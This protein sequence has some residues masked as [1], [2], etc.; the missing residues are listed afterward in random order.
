ML[1][2]NTFR[3]KR[4]LRSKFVEGKYLL[5]SEATDLELEILDV[6]RKTVQN[7]LG[8]A[9]AVE[10]AWKVSRLSPTQLLIQPGEAWVKGLPF[11]FREGKDQLVSGAILSLGTVPVGVTITDDASGAGKII[12]FNDGATTPTNNYRIS[13][14]ATEEL[15]TDVDD[16]FLKNV[17]LTET[18]AQKIRLN[19][20]LNIVPVSLQSTSSLPYRD[21][22]GTA[23]S[24]TNFPNVGG[25]ASPNLQ[26]EVVVTPTA[27]GNGE[28]ISLTVITG[29][30]GI[31]GRDL[32]L[33]VRNNPGLGGGNPFP[34]SPVGQAAFANGTLIDSNGN[35]FY[36]NAIF[37]DTVSTQLVIRIDKEPDQP[38]PE[39]INGSPYTLVK[40]EVFVTDDINGSPQGRLYWNIADIDFNT[41]NGLVHES[42]VT[43]LRD[44]MNKSQYYQEVVNQKFDLQLV[45][46][47]TVSFDAATSLFTWSAPLRLINPYGAVQTIAAGSARLVDGGSLHYI[48]NLS[49]GAI[50]KGTQ[51]VTVSAF[52]ATSTLA[53]VSLA[54]VSVGNII[55]DSAG[56][57]AEITAIDDV[58]DTLTTSPALTANGAATIY[59]DSYGP[60][61]A[62]LSEKGYVLA[63][64][65]GSNI[66]IGS[67]ELQDGE[68]GEIGDGVTQQLLDFIGSTS[69]VDDSPNYT[70][71]NYVVD[72]DSLV[73]SISTLDLA[74]FT[75]A[76]VVDAIQWKAPV[77]NFAALPL[78]SN[79][80]G[81]VRLVL[82][83]RIAYS[84]DGTSWKPL[85]GGTSLK[86]LGGGT[87]AVTAGGTPTP[88]S[89]QQFTNTSSSGL[90]SGFY[91]AQ[92]FT[93]GASNFNLDSVTVK[94][95]GTGLTGNIEME[96]WG[97]DGFG[98]PDETNVLYSA[99][100]TI[101]ASTLSASPSD[102]TFNFSSVG[103][104]ASTQYALVLIADTLTGPGYTVRLGSGYSGGNYKFAASPGTG[105]WTNQALDDWYFDIQG[106]ENSFLGGQQL[107]HTNNFA[108]TPGSEAGTTFTCVNTGD[109]STLKFKVDIGLATTSSY[110]AKVYA[111][112]AGL[113]TGAALATST[114][115]FTQLDMNPS[116]NE[117]DLIFNFA[118]GTTL[119]SGVVYA[120]VIDY[121]GNASSFFKTAASNLAGYTNID[122][123]AGWALASNQNSI[124]FDLQLASNSVSLSFTDDMYLEKAGLSYFDN[125]IDV[126]ESPLEFPN[127]YDVAY[128]I[129]NFVSGGPSLSV[130]VDSLD[131]VPLH[132]LI[133]ARREGSD[134]I[135]G[136]SSTR[137]KSGQS[138]KLYAQESIQAEN[139]LKSVD[140]LRS[141]D[142]VTWTGTQL[143]FTSDIILET[144]NSRSGQ[145]KLYSVLTA[146]SPIA[147]ANGEILYVTIDREAASSS[148]SPSIASVMPTS[149]SENLEIVV[150]AKRIDANSQGYLHIP[151]HKQVLDPGQS[152]R[153]GA[154]GSGNASVKAKYLDPI[155]TTLPGGVSVT[156]DGQTGVNGD[157][158]LFTNLSSNNNRIYELSGVGV[159]LVWTAKRAFNGDFDAED[160]DSVRIQS[161]DSFSEQL[162]VFD[163]TNFKVNDTLRFFDGVSSDYWELGSIKTVNL[164]DN[165]TDGEVFSVS[166]TGSENW[167]V[168]YSLSRGVG[169]KETGQLYITSDGTST[170]IARGNSYLSDCGVSFDTDIDSGNI[171]LLY[172]TTNTGTDAVMKLFVMRWSNSAGGPNGIPNYGTSPS[173]S[174]AASGSTGDI[175]YKG[176]SGN[177]AGDTRF[178]WDDSTGVFNLNGLM[179]KGLQGPITLLDNQVAPQAVFSYALT[180][181]FAIIEYSITRNTNT[182]VGRLLVTN[183]GSS[184]SI[185][186]DNIFVGTPGITF[187]AVLS[188]P[189]VI[190]AYTST[191]SGFDADFKYSF[192]YWS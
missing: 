77:A 174:V 79:V 164:L 29:S 168:N 25:S 158:V 172:T 3:A 120:C 21:E 148:V 141:A 48:L 58:N 23:G 37:N 153:L 33:V 64:R 86:V 181:K 171:R 5:A 6:L 66:Y 122:D 34:Q 14:V 101:D 192:R 49:G 166:V 59:L 162:A 20:K 50:Q 36:V 45:D 40:R 104:T 43:D 188:G 95:S 106:T 135:V 42:S 12:T 63:T 132:A 184:V 118:A 17:N 110:T 190:I 142:L 4:Y 134:I 155:S 54:N 150:L 97:L 18:T 103:L 7:T 170:A 157:T 67:Q 176:S 100:N 185:S 13:V 52:G 70:N 1:R 81:D 9:V 173:S 55:V 109:L 149:S 15:I 76:G 144:L 87:L 22:S 113:P 61:K 75:L 28:L 35:S 108:I 121:T 47:G 117:T 72:G 111:T 191:N 19:F 143:E 91:G 124:Y 10:D 31:D 80:N 30:E 187:S 112:S 151:L 62:P 57:V 130:I 90:G 126:S 159:S 82:D 186:D 131:Q 189:N 26:N 69:E 107:L 129:P 53:S 139:K 167:I 119:T 85:T 146:N 137:I 83:T 41:T 116:G 163:G 92:T 38:N 32:Q 60:S 156:I 11:S 105:A 123:T 2:F 46:G 147:L 128:V 183:N 177:L 68:S 178:K 74:L 165:T 133:I 127:D 89:I 180:N 160:G 114:N 152:V 175:Q 115:T 27:A 71:N 179:Y 98:D 136:S 65:S 24:P 51:A 102:Q 84:W 99:I 78:V 154:S 125:T 93:I 39:I 145:T 96:I 169:T 16:P 88:A 161:G 56:Q 73:A 8:D 140:F 138:T 182:S 44:V 94:L